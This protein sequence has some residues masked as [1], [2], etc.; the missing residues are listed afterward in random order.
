MVSHTLVQL[1]GPL[2]R[3]TMAQEDIF[4]LVNFAVLIPL[5]DQLES[6][7]RLKDMG[8]ECVPWLLQRFRDLVGAQWTRPCLFTDLEGVKRMVQS[9]MLHAGIPWRLSVYRNPAL[10]F[11]DRRKGRATISSCDCVAGMPA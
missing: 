5:Y 11:Y 3:S 6:E 2:R 1:V 7:H 9:D 10:P 4:V 8:K